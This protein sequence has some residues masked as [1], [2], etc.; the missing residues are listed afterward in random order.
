MRETL[1]VLALLLLPGSLLFCAEW[2]DRYREAQEKYYDAKAEANRNRSFAET[3]KNPAEKAKALEAAQKAALDMQKAKADMD[4]AA[5]HVKPAEDAQEEKGKSPE[6]NP[7]LDPR[8]THHSW[9]GE[10]GKT[11]GL[12]TNRPSMPSP[13]VPQ[14][15][16]GAKPYGVI[17]TRPPAKQG[18]ASALTGGRVGYAERLGQGPAPAVDNAP[19]VQ[20]PAPQ[21][22]PFQEMR[23]PERLPRDFQPVDFVRN[24]DNWGF[25]PFEPGRAPEAG[26][27]GRM[28]EEAITQVRRAL[29]EGRDA[30]ALTQAEELLHLSPEDS[31]AWHL[32][33]LIL[34]RLGRFAEAAEA[35]RGALGFGGENAKVYETLAVAWVGLERYAEAADAASKALNLDPKAALAYAIRALA[36]EKLGQDAADDVKMATSLR[37]SLFQHS[38][39]GGPISPP[40]VKPSLYQEGGEETSEKSSPLPWVMGGLTLLVFAGGG[41]MFWMKYR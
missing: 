40:S 23:Q 31:R 24:A 18:G 2:A 12:D 38:R 6:A 22:E 14:T 25:V 41:W 16:E 33:A 8:V 32:K 11:G 5:K 10:P 37:P 36:R 3:L 21:A 34:N 9:V 27:R 29:D 13:N 19:A 28:K 17:Y 4:E 20:A 35:A 15:I 26:V 7:A 1:F 39:I 30:E